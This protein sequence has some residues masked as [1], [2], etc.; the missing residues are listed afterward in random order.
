[1]KR[2]DSNQIQGVTLMEVMMVVG[3]LGIASTMIIA[4]IN[5]INSM[6]RQR[7]SMEIQ[8]Q[9]QA[10][11]YLMTRDVR[12]ADFIINMSSNPPYQLDL[13]TYDFTYGYD[14]RKNPRLFEPDNMITISYV[15]HSP[16]G[17]DPQNYLL[18]RV[19][20]DSKELDKKKYLTNMITPLHPNPVMAAT[21]N[22][23]FKEFPVGSARPFNCVQINFYL[24]TGLTKG[25]AQ[26]IKAESM[27]R[28][29]SAIGAP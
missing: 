13:R 14:K 11:L 28:G 15:Y 2:N 8:N 27:V 22:P 12:N 24:E 21:S 3:I 29:S 9:A 16:D 19:I 5:F 10:V 4:G 26:V 1:M 20:K 7:T 23:I 17:S 25:S 6:V 18:R